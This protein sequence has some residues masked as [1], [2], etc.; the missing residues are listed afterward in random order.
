MNLV[1]CEAD[2]RMFFIAFFI[3]L[4]PIYFNHKVLPN[5]PA[6]PHGSSLNSNLIIDRVWVQ[7]CCDHL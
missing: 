5:I 7:V 2:E 4:L 6:V 3:M 1:I